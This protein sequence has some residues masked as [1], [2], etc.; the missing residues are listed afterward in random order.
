VKIRQTVF[1]IIALLV[2]LGCATG[3]S[4]ITTSGTQVSRNGC[5]VD[6]KQICQNALSQPN[7]TINGVQ[8]DQNRLEQ[9]GQRHVDFVL[10]YN[11]PNGELLAALNCQL[12]TQTHK[13]TRASLA[14]GPAI[15]EKAVDYVRS[16]GLCLED[17]AKK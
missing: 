12:D 17:T 13:V 8:Y 16:Q 14:S 10:P 1:A 7:L 6:L 15:D 4:G 3:P 2:A 11:F 9:L 5:A